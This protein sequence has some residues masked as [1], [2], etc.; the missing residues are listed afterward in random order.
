M[1]AIK[2][3]NNQIK[4][5]PK[6]IGALLAAN[7]KVA[8]ELI[9]EHHELMSIRKDL[10]TKADYAEFVDKLCDLSKSMEFLLRNENKLTA[11]FMESME[12]FGEIIVN[13]DSN[14]LNKIKNMIKAN[15]LPN[16]ILNT[17]LTIEVVDKSDEEE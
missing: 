5:A 4:N 6:K 12:V 8:S 1:K 2:M 16:I 15:N 3:F 10:K 17:P 7:S 9:D 13:G 14:M 11:R